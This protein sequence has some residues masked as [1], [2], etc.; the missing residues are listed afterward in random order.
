[1]RNLLLVLVGINIALLIGKSRITNHYVGTL[2]ALGHSWTSHTVQYGRS[3]QTQNSFVG[4]EDSVDT[5]AKQVN[6]DYSIDIIAPNEYLGQGKGQVVP[7]RHNR[8]YALDET[9][10]LVFSG[11]SQFKIT[12]ALLRCTY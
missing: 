4:L 6:I 10:S 11:P 9:C 12:N 8:V 5:R 7:V 2:E 3:I 1:M